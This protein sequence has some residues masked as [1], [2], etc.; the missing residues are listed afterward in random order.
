MTRTIMRRLAIGATI[1]LA[2]TAVAPVVLAWGA[3][4]ADSPA[5]EERPIRQR[6]PANC[7]LLAEDG[8]PGPHGPRVGPGS[9]GPRPGPTPL[10]IAQRLALSVEQRQ[11]ARAIQKAARNDIRALHDAAMDEIE[12]VLTLDQLDALPEFGPSGPGMPGPGLG[13]GRPG[14]GPCGAGMAG[15]GPGGRFG[16]PRPGGPRP[17]APPAA[18]EDGAARPEG[19]PGPPMPPFLVAA[20]QLEGELAL[21]AEQKARLEQIATNLRDSVHARHMEAR[22]AF[23]ALLTP[24]QVSALDAIEAEFPRPGPRRNMQKPPAGSKPAGARTR[25]GTAG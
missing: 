8:N 15:P 16:R 3:P 6:D 13:M 18:E 24:E 9:R 20:D 21:T 19:P 11:Q 25:A 10:M 1:G 5:A 7:R 17:D 4:P 12:T 14:M 23:R 2:A 22:D